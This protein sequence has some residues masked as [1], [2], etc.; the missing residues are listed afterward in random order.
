M[1]K[2]SRGWGTM[3]KDFLAAVTHNVLSLIGTIVTTI[4][5]V[6]FIM[7]FAM[8]LLGFQ[9]GP[10]LGILAFLILPGLFILGLALIPIG[11]VWAVRRARKQGATD[12]EL[13]V[14]DLNRPGTRDALV[15]A[16][17]LTVV[18]VVIVGSATYKGVEVMDST[19]FC[20]A[21]CHTV[22]EPEYTT[23]QRSPHAHV[24]CVDCHIG[25]GV[26]WFVKSKLSGVWQVVSVALDLYPRPIPTPLHNLRPA[27]ET[28]EQCHW[29]TKFIGDRLIIKNTYDD[30]E[31]NTE[32]KTV[33]LMKVG[34]LQ[35]RTSQGI[36]WHVDRN[37]KVRYLTDPSRETIYNVELTEADGTQKLFKSSKK[38]PADTVWRT[39]D[40]LDCHNRPTHIYQQPGEAVDIAIDDGHIDR[41]LP[42][43]KREAVKAL[44][45]RYA[46]H[47]EARAGLA[48][49]LDTFYGGQ[50]PD[51][52]KT[53]ADA[54]GAAGRE[55]GNIYARNVFPRMKVFWNTYPND[56]GHENSP[57]CNRCHDNRHRTA[58]GEKIPRDCDI[59]HAVLADREKNP[60]ILKNLE[61]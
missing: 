5:A 15:V 11:R 61:P 44:K 47:E 40:C 23:Y 29:P 24:K 12:M 59:C 18:N 51:L 17:L 27:R 52:L 35:G 3:V 57:G 36:H 38:A 60:E 32:L 49:T 50:Y 7:L 33:L 2:Q 53:K 55:L 54:I 48:K 4:S 20:G 21:A 19:T 6:L 16:A 45:V 37:I 8:Q 41:E 43:I 34:G 26:D 46:S 10:Y 56:L 42:F 14:I 39:M 28:C 58:D 1:G 9:G 13:P 30:D 31:A 25:P 22:M